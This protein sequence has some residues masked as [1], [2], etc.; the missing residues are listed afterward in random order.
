MSA[1]T[2]AALIPSEAS[3]QLEYRKLIPSLFQNGF[4]T[5]VLCPDELLDSIIRI[6]NLRASR[7]GSSKIMITLDQ[8]EALSLI[9]DILSFDISKWTDQMSSQYSRAV[10]AQGHVGEVRSGFIRPTRE[11]WMQIASAYY[12][13]VLLYGIRSLALDFSDQLLGVP[14]GLGRSH[15]ETISHVTISEIQVVARQLLFDGLRKVSSPQRAKKTPLAK[16]LIWP[17]FVAGVEAVVVPDCASEER[18]ICDVLHSLAK[19][20]GTL[21]L[22]DAKAFLCELKRQVSGS[23]C[24]ATSLFWWD[25]IFGHVKTRCAFFM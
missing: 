19:S 2:T 9:Q 15:S 16:V 20:I 3:R 1:T 8:S 12:A 5:C 24:G 23:E 11:D 17:I 25:D 4:E 7:H 18:F 14:C 13:A 21:T 6:N 10:A 22:R